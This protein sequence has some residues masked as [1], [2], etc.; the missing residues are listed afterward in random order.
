M[1]EL[2]QSTKEILLWLLRLR[3]RFRVTG[4]S[5]L[6]LLKPGDEVLIDPRA[7]RRQRPLVGDIVVLFHPQEPEQKII[8]RVV[9]VCVDG[10]YRVQGD[11]TAASTDSRHFGLVG[12]ELIIGR[13]TGRFF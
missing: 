4:A 7:Y 8:K 11:N 9:E 5:M 6:P 12:E 13:V 3:R 10:R 1:K 2:T